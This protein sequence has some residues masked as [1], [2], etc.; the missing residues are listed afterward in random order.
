[1]IYNPI[2]RPKGK[3]REYAEDFALNI[4]SG[5]PHNCEYCYGPSVLRRP[6]DIFHSV[7]EPR[8]GIVEATRKQLEHWTSRGVTGKTVHLCFACDPFPYGHDHT[9][10]IEI[11][12][13]IKES[14]NHVQLLTKNFSGDPGTGER[15]DLAIFR[16]IELLDKNDWFGITIDGTK[17]IYKNMETMGLEA[18]TVLY[19]MHPHTNTWVSFEPVIDEDIV[20][21][22]L[23]GNHQ[24]I[25]KA[26]FGKLNYRPKPDTV[27]SWAALG[28]RAERLCGQLAV[29]CH[30][31]ES[32]R[33]EMRK[34]EQA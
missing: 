25:D 1:M 29:E 27:E 16:L 26:E 11:I 8:A 5:C 19:H 22:F 28:D 21:Q 14:G 9:P 31:K 10:T 6:R 20:L 23:K 34:G 33:F 2:Y 18:S 4:Y 3:A 7:V 17:G 32:L 15:G 13:A 24:S 12:K 30:I